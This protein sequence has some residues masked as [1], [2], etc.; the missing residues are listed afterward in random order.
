MTTHIADDGFVH[1]VA[2][3]ADRGRVG[4]AA[5]AEHRNLGRAAADVDHHGADRLGHR[6]IG[7]DGG[8]HGLEDQVDV[9]CARIRGRIADRAAF[10]RGRSRGDA[11]HDFGIAEHRLLA[12]HLLDEVLDH[13]LGHFDVGDH[14]VA[15]RADRLD[16]VGSLAH[17]H[18][19]IVAHGLDAAD[20]VDRLDG[21]HRGLVEHD[22]LILDIDERVGGAEVDRHVLRAEFEEIG[23][24]AHGAWCSGDCKACAAS[25][26]RGGGRGMGPGYDMTA[27]A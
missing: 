7:T 25:R 11:D 24:E 18:L 1:L 8:G 20:A 3:G 14:A 5:Q 6:H 4:K 2:A 12:M 21:D 22:A 16:A 13:L 26:C 9:R 17:H 15:Q 23:Q 10:D 27:C 19:C